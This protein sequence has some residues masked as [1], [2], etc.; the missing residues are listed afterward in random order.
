MRC[1]CRSKGSK[2][3]NKKKENKL[4]SYAS[5]D[6]SVCLFRLIIIKQRS[7]ELKFM[8]FKKATK[9]DEIFTNDLTLCSKCQI[10]GEDFVN[11]RGLL[12]K[13]EL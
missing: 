7:C 12:I 8:Y 2:K 10:Y 5:Q 3:P 1:N 13:Y 11:F 9:N 4:P 6:L